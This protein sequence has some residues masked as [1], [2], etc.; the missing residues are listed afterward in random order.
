MIVGLLTLLGMAALWLYVAP[1]IENAATRNIL[2][3]TII[4]FGCVFA[5]DVF[6]DGAKG[7]YARHRRTPSFRSVRII[8]TP[9]GDAPLWVREKWI[10]LD[11]PIVGNVSRRSLA[12]SIDTK[13]TALSHWWAVLRRRTEIIHGYHVEAQRAVDILSETSPEAANWWRQNCPDMLRGDRHF[14][15]HAE[16]CQMNEV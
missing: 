5:I 7:L 4:L 8:S 10:G 3:G 12:L 6:I 11:L 9:P 13:S 15:F 2:F 16:A 1:S 14:V